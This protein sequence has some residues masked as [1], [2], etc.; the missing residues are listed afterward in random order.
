MKRCSQ[1]TL[2]FSNDCKIEYLDRLFQDY[3]LDLQ[4]YIDLICNEKLPLEKYLSSKSLPKIRC[5]YSTYKGLIYKQ[6]SEM[7][8][9]QNKKKIKTK[10]EV[11]N[12]SIML[13]DNLLK[14]SNNAKSFD[15][16]ISIRLPYKLEG[17]KNR[18]E[19]I[20]LP[21]KQHKQSLKFKDWNRKKTVQ[22]KK[23]NGNYY[24]TF[25]Y[26]KEELIKKECGES[27]GIDI[28]Y[29]KLIATSDNQFYGTE[30]VNIYDKISKKKQGSKNFKQA[31]IQRDQTI[32]QICN[33]LDLSNVSTLCI[34]AL[35]GVKHKSKF[36]KKFNNKLQRW[37]YP[38]VIH[39]LEKLSEEQGI[40]LVKVSPN[41]T[42]QT[43]SKCGF[44]HREN[45]RGEVYQCIN[46]GI[47]LDAD[48]NAS[49][50]ILHRGVYSPSTKER[51][52]N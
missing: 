2:K 8:R 20:R 21:I 24:L 11:K 12:V 5:N 30:I 22:L 32:N 18:Y 45:R 48:Y 35:K 50:N 49:L 38:K 51:Q 1:H 10:P 19:K 7:I 13:N 41:Y 40:N 43:C 29:K 36:S 14:Y 28:G 27:L 47:I 44:I 17:Y 33:Q 3:Q 4:D 39:K 9:G 34:E 31:L 42:S 25:F 23:I 26:E 46:C 52:L 37:N 15:E 16:F 6:A